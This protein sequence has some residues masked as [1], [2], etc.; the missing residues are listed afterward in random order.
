MP[1][2]KKNQFWKLRSSH[3]RDKIF[4]S[5]LMLEASCYEYFEACDKQPLKK[6]NVFSNGRKMT[7]NLMRAFTLKGLFIFLDINRKTW[8]NYKA[9]EDFIAIIERIEDI[10]YTQ[11]FEGAAAGLL[12]ENI[13]ARELGLADKNN[14]A[15]DNLSDDQLDHLVNK[16]IN[17]N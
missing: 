16:I 11:K 9:N 7:T 5:P 13:I 17:K 3:G 15:L 8:E 1:A 10:I 6:Q 14:I 2:P 4:E 12:K